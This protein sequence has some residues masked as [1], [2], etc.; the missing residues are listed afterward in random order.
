MALA[1]AAEAGRL[2]PG[3]LVL[4]IGFGAGMSWASAVLEWAA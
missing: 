4:L 1:D 2:N 3:D